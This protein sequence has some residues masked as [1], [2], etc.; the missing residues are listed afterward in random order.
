MSQS[1]DNGDVLSVRV[2][3]DLKASFMKLAEQDHQTKQELFQKLLDHYQDSKQAKS[4]VDLMTVH[5]EL[6]HTFSSLEERLLS[7]FEQYNKEVE[8]MRKKAHDYDRLEEENKKLMVL[9]LEQQEEL[10]KR[11]KQLEDQEDM[12]NYLTLEVERLHEEEGGPE[13]P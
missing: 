2:G 5:Q 10:R 3:R 13:M 1:R 9:M 7:I 11:K 6:E 4:I 12:L 8:S